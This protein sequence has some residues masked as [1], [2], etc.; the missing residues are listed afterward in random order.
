MMR[1]SFL[2]LN[3]LAI[4]FVIGPIAAQACDGWWAPRPVYYVPSSS[5]YYVVPSSPAC[6]YRDPCGYPSCCYYTCPMTCYDY[7]VPFQGAAG[8]M[9]CVPQ[10][11]ATIS[12][13]M[14]PVPDR[15]ATP[16]GK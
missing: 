1:K 5:Y 13:S 8:C 11:A 12:G 16:P 2:V 15:L 9:S 4:A 7:A 14:Q 6:Y 10:K 3:L